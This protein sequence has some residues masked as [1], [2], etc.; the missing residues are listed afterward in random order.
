MSLPNIQNEWQNRDSNGVI[1]PW[2]TESFLRVLQSWDLA[3]KRIFEWGSGYSTIWLSNKCKKLISVEHDE[4]WATTVRAAV[5][6]NTEVF[7]IPGGLTYCEKI[8]EFEPFDIVIIDGDGADRS[9]CAKPALQRVKAGGIIILDNADWPINAPIHHLLRHNIRHSYP[10]I[11]H[12]DW[13][14]DYWEINNFE[15]CDIG[16]EKAAT[17][18]KLKINGR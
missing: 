4:A 16:Y 9:L 14:T 17:L 15:P 18:R 1:L 8:L 2:Y 11:G 5:N 6:G 7:H 10:Q 12:P 13:R 3:N